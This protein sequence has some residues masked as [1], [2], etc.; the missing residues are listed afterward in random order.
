MKKC[1]AP[2]I[3]VIFLCGCSPKSDS[4]EGIAA[5]VL[6]SKEGVDIQFKPLQEDKGIDVASRKF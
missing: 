4:L 1:I 6:K 3:A 2:W 5:D